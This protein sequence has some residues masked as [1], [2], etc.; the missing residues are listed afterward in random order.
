MTN[1]ANSNFALLRIFLVRRR[2]VYRASY[3]VVIIRQFV[4]IVVKINN[5]E[6]CEFG[7]LMFDLP[8]IFIRLPRKF[9]LFMARSVFT[10]DILSILWLVSRQYIK[11]NL[12]ITNWPFSLFHLD[13]FA[14]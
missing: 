13:Y 5:S 6:I 9:R 12:K 3:W 10:V 4:A 7:V 2:N 11:P 14:L 8:R 1:F